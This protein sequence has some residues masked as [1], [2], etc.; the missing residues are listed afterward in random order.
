MIL[1]LDIGNTRIKWA[2]LADGKLGA[3]QAEVHLEAELG[4]LLER[5]FDGP[6][7]ERVLASNVAG[8]LVAAALRELCEE[9]FGQRPELLIPGSELCGVKNGYKDPTRL[10]ADRWA[11]VIGAFHRHGG[12][13]CVMDAGTAITVDAVDGKGKHLGGLIAPGPQT[14]RR[15]LA[16]STASLR[17]NGEGEFGLLCRETRSAISSGG[18]HTAAGFLERMHQLVGRELGTKTRF[19]LTGGDAGR[20]AEL[21]PSRFTL[22]PDLVLQGL[23]VVAGSGEPR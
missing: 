4:P 2:R 19:L 14:M 3:Q 6:A 17:D 22:V 15:A 1:L 11:G 13:A 16:G 8:P 9:R 21:V 23:A 7:P 10:G 12:P 18:W 20:L 5:V